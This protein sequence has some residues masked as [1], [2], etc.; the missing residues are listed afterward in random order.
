MLSARNV[1]IYLSKILSLFSKR[2]ICFEDNAFRLSETLCNIIFAW[3]SFIMDPLSERWVGV[4]YTMHHWKFRLS[5]SSLIFVTKRLERNSEQ[6]YC[7]HSL[8]ISYF[9]TK[10]YSSRRIWIIEMKP[11]KG[12]FVKC[13][14]NY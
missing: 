4:F 10:T 14:E 8:S 2:E 13:M 12:V 11:Q 7:W 9:G 3:P 6:V 1:D 5:H